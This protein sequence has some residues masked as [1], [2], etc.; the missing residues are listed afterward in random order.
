MR[1]TGPI[2]ALRG[3]LDCR[4][5]REVGDEGALT[6]V[7]LW[8]DR[9]AWERHALS[10]SFRQILILVELSLEPPEIAFQTI[11]T[12]WGLPYLTALRRNVSWENEQGRPASGSAAERFHD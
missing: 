11:Q 1:G 8:H 3:C 12:T 6:L 5:Y 9:A 2:R 4:L 10:D 7:E